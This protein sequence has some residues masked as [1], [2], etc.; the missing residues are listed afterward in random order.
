MICTLTFWLLFGLGVGLIAKALHPGDEK[1]GL[2]P[3]IGVGV[4][5][6]F[7]GGVIQWALSL[8]GSFHPAGFLFSVLGGVLCC[9]A[10]RWYSLKNSPEGSKDFF[11]RLR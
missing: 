7:V 3:T 5:G 10:Y 4:A 8:G 6:S 2:I 1:M 9:M 11:G